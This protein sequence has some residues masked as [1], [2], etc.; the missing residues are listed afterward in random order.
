[1]KRSE[2]VRSRF[3]AGKNSLVLL[4]SMTVAC[5]FLHQAGADA[6]QILDDVKVSVKSGWKSLAKCS[7]SIAELREERKNLPDSRWWWTD[8]SDKDKEIRK[9]L[10]RVRELLLSTTPRFSRSSPRSQRNSRKTEHKGARMGKQQR[11]LARCC[12]CLLV[13]PADI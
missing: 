4:A 8:K 3:L 10:Q 9:Q 2:I 13:S 12:P 6:G 1:M 11:G 7:D 5:A